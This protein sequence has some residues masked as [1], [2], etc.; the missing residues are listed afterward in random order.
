MSAKVES[1]FRA[2]ICAEG[3]RGAS[4]VDGDLEIA[5]RTDYGDRLPGCSQSKCWRRTFRISLPPTASLMAPDSMAE[6]ELP[7][8]EIRHQIAECIHAQIRLP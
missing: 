6:A 3:A 8:G 7:R 2:A 1:N 5:G 4:T